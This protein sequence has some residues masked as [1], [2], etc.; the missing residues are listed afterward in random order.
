MKHPARSTIRRYGRFAALLVALPC[1]MGAEIYRWVDEN[2]VVNYTQQRPRNVDV[3]VDVE[4][5]TTRTG[6]RGV[7]SEIPVTPAPPVA[8][9]G[10]NQQGD[11]TDDQQA[12]LERLRSTESVRQEQVAEIRTSNCKQARTMLQDLQ[13]RGRLR[14]RDGNSVRVMDEDERQQRIGEAQEGVAVNCEA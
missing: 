2:G 3:D 6:A 12:M 10:E 1:L 11:L 13:A 4:P 9:V 7:S 8:S 14:V 5:I